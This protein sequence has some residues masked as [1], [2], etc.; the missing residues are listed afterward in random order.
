MQTYQFIAKMFLYRVPYFTRQKKWKTSR[1]QQ[2]SSILWS[3]INIVKYRV[4]WY[5][6]ATNQ[7]QLAYMSI[8]QLCKMREHNMV[9]SRCL[10][11][12][13]FMIVGLC[14]SLLQRPDISFLLFNEN[15]RYSIILKK[16]MNQTENIYYSIL[17]RLLNRHFSGELD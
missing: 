12:S 11:I 14:V 9:Y 16:N 2:L 3:I 13:L 15:V 5:L 17:L 10:F 1:L 4:N 7:V 8:F 6:V